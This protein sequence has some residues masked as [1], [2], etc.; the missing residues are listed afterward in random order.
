MKQLPAQ[1][2]KERRRLIEENGTIKENMEKARRE[3]DV[4]KHII[5]NNNA[6]LR[7]LTPWRVRLSNMRDI[8]VGIF[9]VTCIFGFCAYGFITFI[10]L[11]T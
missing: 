3:I 2:V 9:I 4:G 11:F 7:S 5:N 6:K 8:F 10:Q 1:H